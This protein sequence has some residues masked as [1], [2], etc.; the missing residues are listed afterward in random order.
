MTQA[1]VGDV[2]KMSRDQLV[3]TGYVIAGSPH[4]VVEKMQE[5]KS[6]LCVGNIFYHMHIGK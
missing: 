3:N 4:T 2:S 1:A 6:T 5:P